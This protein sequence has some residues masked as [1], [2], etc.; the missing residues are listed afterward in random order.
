MFLMRKKSILQI[1]LVSLFFVVAFDVNA[2]SQLD[3]TKAIPS[4]FGASYDLVL[5]GYAS[6]MKTNCT[7]TGLSLEVGNNQSYQYVYKIGYFYRNGAWEPFTFSNAKTDSDWI[8]GTANASINLSETERLNTNYVVTYVCTWTGTAWKCGCR[9]KAC[10]S[11]HWQLQIFKHPVGDTNSNICVDK[12]IDGYDSCAV[13]ATGDDNK[14]IDCDDNK[15]AVNPNGLEV[16]DTFDNNC[17]GKIDEGC[18]DDKD[19]YCDSGMKLYGGNTMCTLTVF[20]GEGTSGSDCDD[21]N[22]SVNPGKA[23][24]CDGVDN[25]CDKNTDEGCVCVDSDKDGYDTCGTGELGDDGKAEDCNDKAWERSPGAVEICDGVDNDCD[26]T[27]DEGGVCCSDN[28]GDTYDACSV[29]AE[30]DD[31]KVLDCDDASWFMNPGAPE[32]CDN[33]DN[34]CNG[35]KD[36][37]C[38]ED[39]DGYCSRLIRFYNYPV[40]ACPKTNIANDSFGNDC[41]ETDFNVNPG[42]VEKC[43]GIDDDCDAITDENCSCVNS[44]TQTCGIDTG[45]CRVGSQTC[46]NGT[47]GTCAGEIVAVTEICSDNIDNDCDGQTDEGCSSC[48]DNDKDGFDNCAIGTS[49]DDGKVIDCNDNE[50]WSNPGGVETCDSVDNNCS[51]VKDE[52][53]DDD[54]DGFC[55][56]AMKLYSSNS[57][58]PSTVFTGNDMNGNDCNDTNLN[59]N[60]SKTEV[61]GNSVDDNC[62][63]G[64]DEGCGQSDMKLVLNY[65]AETVI[66]QDS[67]VYFDCSSVGGQNPIT[68]SLS[69]SIDGVFYSGAENHYYN[70]SLSVGMHTI[71]VTATDANLKSVSVTKNL[72]IVASSDFAVPIGSPVNGDIFYLG[73]TVYFYTGGV[74][75]G[76]TNTY[77]WESDR[78]GIISSNSYFNSSSLSLGIHNIKL[79]ATN[80]VNQVYTQTVQIEI[81]NQAFVKVWPSFATVE[82]GEKFY[83]SPMFH[84]STDRATYEFSSNIDGVLGSSFQIDTTR[85]TL[86]QHQITVKATGDNGQ[87][88]SAIVILDIIAPICYDEDKDGYGITQSIACSSPELDCSDNNSNINPGIVEDCDNNLDDDCDGLVDDC[89]INIEMQLPSVDDLIIERATMMTIRLKAVGAIYVRSFL[90][91]P[92]GTSLVTVTLYDDGKHND[93]LANDGVWGNTWRAGGAGIDKYYIDFDILRPGQS[94]FDKYDNVR[95]FFLS[96]PPKCNLVLDSGSSAQ[97]LDIL[98]VPDQFTNEEMTVFAGKAKTAADYLV[99]I[100]PFKTQKN[101]INVSWVEVAQNLGCDQGANGC[102]YPNIIA[103]AASCPWDEIVVLA[104]RSFRSWATY[105]GYAMVSA[106]DSNFKW[107]IVHELG[108]SFASL[109]DEYVEAN[110]PIS[111]AQV[112]ASINCDTSSTCTKWSGVTGTGC[113]DGCYYATGYYR[114]INSGL[115]RS[116]GATNFGVLNINHINTLF[117]NYQ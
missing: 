55:D 19:L 53:C 5:P 88:A 15:K 115:M 84:G 46:A 21:T 65:P 94:V 34:N 43:N 117:N 114:S 70:N 9:D 76:D 7:S 108:H 8:I 82:K 22:S 93:L 25:D 18:D 1:F 109:R 20:K 71:T 112:N 47:W 6:L 63:S 81:V 27:S 54:R 103:S 90:Q 17:D 2:C 30:G 100:E 105:N 33:Y 87:T 36:E 78:D 116:S 101:K 86:G 13:G 68:Y 56:N 77:R 32:T 62:V 66:K 111:A 98:L 26:E 38:D 48:A 12:D 10:T 28:D 96:E 72:Q 42:V 44:R 45:A 29:G 3:S 97:K 99:T 104:D 73:S 23:E 31:G 35:Q 95:A 51:G 110:K 113:F 85:M 80:A 4:G 58:C 40:S 69:S 92:D 14:A 75:G 16:C 50:V 24:V 74:G 11:S 61:C 57:M 64:V 83:I 79:T 59:V 107:V 37:K 49:G 106:V 39:G 91:S 52:G 41:G 67:G 89:A 60:P 102:T